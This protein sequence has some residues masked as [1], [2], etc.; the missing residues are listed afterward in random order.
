MKKVF[1]FL[2]VSFIGFALTGSAIAG[3]KLKLIHDNTSHA[4]IPYI[5]EKKGFFKAEGIAFLNRIS[6]YSSYFPQPTNTT[7]LYGLFWTGNIRH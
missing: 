5:A 2:V 4:A 3:G 6:E 7:L 1:W